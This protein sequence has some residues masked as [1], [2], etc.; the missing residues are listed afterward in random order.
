MIGRIFVT[1]ALWSGCGGSDASDD[2]VIKCE[3]PDHT[4]YTCVPLALGSVGCH[5]GPTWMRDGDVHQ[6]DAD[7]S[8]PKGCMAM[9]PDCSSTYSGGREFV[10]GVGADGSSGW[11]ELL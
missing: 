7:Q 4:T 9:I 2:T 8:Y 1:V 6:D 10:C 11:G 3:A 5:G